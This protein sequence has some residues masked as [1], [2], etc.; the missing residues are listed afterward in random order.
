[1]TQGRSQNLGARSQNKAIKAV[2]RRKVGGT[3]VKKYVTV[4]G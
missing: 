1:M 4:S 3:L 2:R